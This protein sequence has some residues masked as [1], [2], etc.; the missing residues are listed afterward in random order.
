MSKMGY[1]EIRLFFTLAVAATSA[2]MPT[3]RTF[4]DEPRD[5]LSIEEALTMGLEELMTVSLATGTPRPLAEA[6]AITT[7]LTAED[8]RA[9]GATD[10]EQVLESVPGLHVSRS[11]LAYSPLFV[12]RGLWSETSPYVLFLQNGI[13]LTLWENGS[14]GAFWGGMPVEAIAR[15]EVI[16]G[17]GSALFGADAVGGVVNIVTKTAADVDGFEAGLRGGSFETGEAWLLYGGERGGFEIALALQAWTTEG[18]REIVETDSQTSLDRLFGT[19]AALAPGPVATGRDGVEA[20]VD[21]ARGDWRLRLGF[22]GRLDLGTGGGFAQ[23]L[24]PIGSTD[25]RRHLADLTWRR[26]DPGSDW[27]LELQLS[28]LRNRSDSDTFVF[29]P[30]VFNGVGF[31]PDGLRI[32]LG[33]TERHLRA[34]AT[35]TYRGAKQH[36]LRLGAGTQRVDYADIES[37]RADDLHGAPLPGGFQDVT[38]DPDLIFG[39]SEERDVRFVFVQDEWRLGRAW[40]VTTGVRWDHYSDFGDTVNPRLAVVFKATGQLTAK[41]LYGRAF[42][43]PSY[44]ELYLVNNPGVLGN[45]K[46]E[47]EIIDTVELGFSYHPTADARLGFNLFAYRLEDLI[48]PVGGPPQIH[49]N[50]GERRGEGFEIEGRWK[51]GTFE[52]AGNFAWQE[53]TEETAGADVPHAP[54]QQLYLRAGWRFGRHWHL[55]TVFNAVAERHRA[56]GDARPETRDFATL[57]LTLRRER[58]TKYLDLAVLVY[59]L[60]DEDVREPS[61]Y[62]PGPVQQF[63]PGDL[64]RAGRSI[65]AELRFRR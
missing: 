59:N 57:D 3:S 27:D 52:L 32:F 56:P 24:D 9:I 64:P 13:P 23:A 37:K 11:H 61:V 19:A 35:A 2:G 5:E 17:P 33:S 7:V 54:G 39:V 50:I 45:P 4:A 12:M 18:Q 63:I 16:R 36:R 51:A 30:G 1:L 10:L 47:P 48:L 21:L 60:F 65:L 6:P 44:R 26:T 28:Y 25:R 62:V 20:N 38:D 8:I 14:I 40:E 29:P 46:L 31:F 49:R 55:G 15:I 41:L 34:G 43:P 42:R 53:S 58:L 22:Q